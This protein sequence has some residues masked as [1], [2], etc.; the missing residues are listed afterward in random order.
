VKLPG[1]EEYYIAYASF[2]TPL[3]DYVGDKNVKGC[4]REVCLE[5]VSF[6][7]AG[8]IKKITPTHKGIQEAVTANVQV[9][10]KAEAGGKVRAGNGAAQAEVTAYL[11]YQGTKTTITAVPDNGK[12]FDRWSDGVKTTAR[13]DIG[14]KDTTV[15]AYFKNNTHAHAYTKSV[16]PATTKKDGKIVMKCA[17]GHVKS[18]SVIPPIKSVKLSAETFTYNNKAKMPQVTVY[19]KNSR[20][21]S[22]AYYSVTKPSGRKKI[23]TY[24]ATVKLKGNY[25]GTV[26]KKFKIV[27]AGAKFTK[28]TAVKKGFTAKWKKKTGVSGYELQYS[29]SKKFTKAKIKKVKK[30]KAASQKITKLKAKKKYYVRIRTYKMVGK[31]KYVSSWSKPKTVRTK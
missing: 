10:Y 5:K 18:T 21:V 26:T 30:A 27:P 7:A 16:T 17:C 11:T 2:G 1:T 29:T 3:S 25:S 23:G 19:D 9:V 22:A 28:V 31:Q 4:H 14:A 12:V 8:Y 24:K 6:D 13:T 15:T 20:K